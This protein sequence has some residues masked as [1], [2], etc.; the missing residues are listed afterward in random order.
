MKVYV[1]RT[2]CSGIGMCEMLADAVFAVGDDGLGEVIDEAPPEN[3][4]SAVEEAIA[5]CPTGALSVEN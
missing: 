1:D 4:R 3:L 5:S 2:R